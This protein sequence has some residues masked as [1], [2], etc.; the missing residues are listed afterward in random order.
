VIAQHV[1]ERHLHQYRSKE[2]RALG[3]YRSNEK[4]T[5]GAPC[6]YETLGPGVSLVY[7]PLGCANKIIEA[8]LLAAQDTRLMPTFTVLTSSSKVRNRYYTAVLQP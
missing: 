2:L 8:V 6:S 5:V 7:Q 1:E 3:K 4:A